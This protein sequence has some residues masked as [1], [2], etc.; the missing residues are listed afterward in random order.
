M[1]TG[2]EHLIV[3]GESVDASAV[4]VLVAVPGAAMPVAVGDRCLVTIQL[5]D[6]ALH[7]MAQVCRKERGDD[8][9][10]YVGLEYEELAP[11]DLERLRAHAGDD[12]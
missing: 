1:A 10:Y 4:G 8:G 9:R 6:G 12:A 11:G 2:S 5:R 7:V 3:G